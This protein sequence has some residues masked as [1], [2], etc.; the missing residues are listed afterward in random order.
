MRDLPGGRAQIERRLPGI[1]RGSPDGARDR[2]LDAADAHPQRADPADA[3]SWLWPRLH[4]RPRHRRGVL[5]TELF[6]GRNR[7][8]QSLPSDRARLRARD[9]EAARLLGEAAA[10][11][12]GYRRM[13]VER[14]TVTVG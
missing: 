1:C 2:L 13:T 7:S 6:S 8:P 11:H 9:Q 12:G 10:P 4:L 3:R 14:E 5:R